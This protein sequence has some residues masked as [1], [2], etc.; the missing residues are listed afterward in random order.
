M[1]QLRKHHVVVLVPI[2]V[3]FILESHNLEA[4]TTHL[5][6]IYGS[7][8]YEVENF[9]VWVRVV[10]NRWSHT[11]NNAPRAVR[12]KNQDWVV[13]CAELGMDCAVHIIPL[14][15]IQR[16]MRK[17]SRKLSCCVTMETVAFRELGVIAIPVGLN[18]ALNVLHRSP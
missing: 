9:F 3:Y 6:T 2:G 10:F 1:H 7:F 15:K 5:A 17:S 18:K 12:S 8:T 16:I 11:D 14:V 4:L 13:D